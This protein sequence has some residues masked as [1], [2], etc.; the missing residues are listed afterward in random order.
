MFRR[1]KE[2]SELDRAISEVFADMV[3]VN[4]D[5]DEYAKMADQLVKLYPLREIDRS[6]WPSPDQWLAASAHLTG[7]LLV[8]NHER[9]HVITTKAWSFM[10]SLR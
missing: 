10:K 6:K 4:A 9:M 2:P 1:K 7:I 8:V 3:V 5:S